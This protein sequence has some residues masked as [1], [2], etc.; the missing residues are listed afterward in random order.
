MFISFKKLTVILI[1]VLFFQACGYKM[2]G[3]DGK[4][5]YTLSIKNVYNMTPEPDLEKDIDNVAV[6]FFSSRD[7]LGSKNSSTY[8]SEL[9]L[10]ELVFES[11]IVTKTGQTGT[12]S[13]R[14]VL[15]ILIK[16]RTGQEIFKG[17][18]EGRTVY[19]ISADLG[20]TRT[21]RTEAIQ[22]ILRLAL[23][24]FYHDFRP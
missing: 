14:C 20:K 21:N 4:R 16:D 23:M 2:A 18:F 15:E 6:S 9:K 3:L 13:V 12:A 11:R 17:N 5:D 7:V 8:T 24:D 10:K 19:D 22:Y 1:A